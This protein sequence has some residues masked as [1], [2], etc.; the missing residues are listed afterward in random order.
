MKNITLEKLIYK[1]Y[2]KTSLASIIFIETILV[3]VYF[4]VS[5]NII[6]KNIDYILKDLQKNTTSIVNEKIELINN[7]LSEMES[8]VNILQKEHQDFFTNKLKFSPNQDIE[9]S[10]ASNGM[11]YKVNNNG[12]SS[13]VV[14]NET[15]IDDDLLNELKN[16]EIFDI[17]F[18]TIVNHEDDVVAA[19]FNSRKNYTRYYPFLDDSF[20]VFPSDINMTN[21]NFY[22]LADANHNPNRKSVWTDVYLDPAHKGWLLSIIAPIYNKDILEG[23]TGI[24]VS[25]EN[26]I[27]S[28]L[29]LKLPYDGKSFVMNKNGNLIAMQNELTNI[30]GID[31]LNP[32]SYKKDEKIEETVYKNLEF[33]IE[34]FKNEEL[35]N[36]INRLIKQDLSQN[37]VMINGKKYL[38]FL[39]EVKKTNW[40]VIS[41]IEEDKVLEN[42][43]NL[44]QE[45]KIVGY[46]VVGFIF[47]FYILFFIFLS[48]KA[49][50][51][52][53][54][55]VEPLKNMI[56]VTK[57]IG[58]NNS[59]SFDKQSNIIEL[60]ELN[61]NFVQ[62]IS[63][64]DS[65]TKKLIDEEAQIIYQRKLAVTDSLTG[66][67][68]RR[69]LEEFSN[70]YLKTVKR[71]NYSLSLMMIDIDDF[72]KINDS[73]GH[74]I[75]D[76]VLVD[77]SKMVR[78]CIRAN[79]MFVRLGGDEFL[80]LLLHTNME[81]SSVVAQKILDKVKDYDEKCK[82][83][84]SIGI[85]QIQETDNNI[86]EM[87]KR[88]DI[89]LY[90]AKN[91]G[92]NKFV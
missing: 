8:L 51:F 30:F 38:L 68:N 15:K 67:Y 46:L 6:N 66:C 1:N 16:S 50:E 71:E 63:E 86:N 9:F 59:I 18:K 33:N 85:S 58:E 44:E 64:L 56:L 24:D 57:N 73:C 72:K 17:T 90:K 39:E 4:L 53:S 55:I 40:Y 82:F 26:F 47:I 34:N 12:G 87:M 62:L 20:D 70:E 49:K 32:Y 60:D 31:N 13:V 35:V 65:K 91:E 80:I 36:T 11:F 88:A 27:S 75:G 84:V 3:L 23:V 22:Y 29:K 74:D 89:S 78:D 79:D 92:K 77:F 45:Y 43:K 14:S 5:N 76:K 25:L 21:Y 48:K 83:T 2:L 61:K 41:F 54:Q 7:K 19:Y 28:F 52:V 81:N 10:F 37:S 69:F 42:V